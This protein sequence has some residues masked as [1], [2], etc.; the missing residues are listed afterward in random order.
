NLFNKN[1]PL[2]FFDR[3]RNIDGVSSVT[4]DDFNGAYEATKHLIHQGCKRIAHLSNDRSIEIFQNRYLGYKQ[5]LIDHGL[6]CDESLVVETASKV[7]EG[8]RI[9]NIFLNM[10][11][12]PDAIFSSSDFTAL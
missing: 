10:E 2:I 1:V 5:A 3:K 4:I 6:E 7:D 8:R 11:R 9:T 12:P